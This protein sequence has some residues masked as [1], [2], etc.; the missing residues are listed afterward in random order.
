[1]RALANRL[2][3]IYEPLPGYAFISKSL[4]KS[5]LYLSYKLRKFLLEYRKI[6][7]DYVSQGMPLKY[8]SKSKINDVSFPVALSFPIL[9]C[10]CITSYERMLPLYIYSDK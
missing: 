1:M 8:K 4:G 5:A 6:L 7:L 9:F 10:K 2:G 3:K